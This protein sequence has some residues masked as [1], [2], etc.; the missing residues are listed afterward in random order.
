[1]S[2]E[3]TDLFA[4][5]SAEDSLAKTSRWLDDVLDLLESEAD[6]GMSSTGSSPL[7]VPP[8]L[9]SKTSLEFCHPQTAGTWEPYSGHWGTAGMGSPT[10]CLTFNSSE[11]PSDGGVCG[12][13]DVLEACD[14]PQKYFLSA[15]ACLGI[16]RRAA[17]RGR[18]LPKELRRALEQVAKEP[19]GQAIAEG[20][21]V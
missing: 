16:L 21:I 1:M 4:T 17:Q 8:G 6:F 9:L 20:R 3:S 12:L 13:S 14:V 2:D 5:C 19:S 15:K 11:S 10:G 7:T 18:E